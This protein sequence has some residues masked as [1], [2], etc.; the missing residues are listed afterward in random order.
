MPTFLAARVA[1]APCYHAAR[2]S[3]RAAST[4]NSNRPRIGVDTGGTFTDLVRIGSNGE[5]SNGEASNREAS[6][7]A[8]PQ[9]V[10]VPSTPADPGAA[11]AAGCAELDATGARI[12]HGT[13][14]GLN[15]LLTRSLGRAALVTNTGFRDVLELA[16][17]ARPD[18]YALHPTKPAPVIP[19]ALTFEVDE[20]AWPDPDTGALT[21]VTRASA[22]ELDALAQRLR[23]K[24]VEAVAVV[25]LH[26]YADPS[27]EQ[28]VAAHLAQRLPDVAFTTSATLAP[29][30][31]EYERA[32]TAAINASLQPVVARYVARLEAALVGEQGQGAAEL[33]LLQSSG[34]TLSAARAAA[35]PARVLLSGPAGGVQGAV[36][37]AEEA[38]VR[39]L[40]GLVTLD[41]G[42]TSTDIAFVPTADAQAGAAELALDPPDVAGFPLALP[43][44]DMHLIGCGGGS[45]ARVD[46]GGALDVGPES[47]GADPGPV[48]YGRSTTP[49]LTDA[50]VEQGHVRAGAFLGGT[51]ELDTAAVAR[52][53]EALAGKLG[54]KARSKSRARGSAADAMVRIA[55]AAMARATGAMTLQRGRDPRGLT[56][57][58]FGGAGGLMAAELAR[59]LGMPRVLIPRNPGVL[60]AVGL[61]TAR[62]SAEV[63]RVWLADLADVTRKA[64]RATL[65]ELRA[66]LRALAQAEGLAPRE[67]EHGA[68]ATLRYRG[69]TFE[70]VLPATD[71][72]RPLAAAFNAAHAHHFGHALEDLAVQLTGVVLR[73]A[74]RT[75]T[76]RIRQPRARAFTVP[77][78]RR[79][80]RAELAPG[81]TFEGPA[82]VVEY[83][84]TTAIPAGVRVRVTAGAHLLLDLA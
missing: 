75:Q 54:I 33:V 56:L 82:T 70:L 11:I 42:G 58:A 62:F 61:A 77:E 2:M 39:A 84:G 57:V 72:P 71:D 34:G 83:S 68:R 67:L 48:A 27:A 7:R 22:A 20:R 9:I 35:E 36:A 3:P 55:R 37:A 60:S 44:L 63:G 76:S 43:S 10:K 18:I 19:R 46:A 28:R 59:D 74:Q 29:K 5:A 73:G 26:S 64:W 31:R 81:H 78:G 53:F 12:V 51:L 38:G 16:R 50:F 15:A 25:L 13:T 49:T 40:G 41:M 47:A 66:E 14:V 52:A 24:R 80:D 4:S 21:E 23:A 6:N 8:A 1:R 69:Q 45:L 17:Q 32:S 65:A 30:L 79:I